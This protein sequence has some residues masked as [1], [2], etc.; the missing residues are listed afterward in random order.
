M[1]DADVFTY[2]LVHPARVRPWTVRELAEHIGWDRASLG[3]IR[4][5]KRNTLP[6]DIA[7]RIAEAVGVHPNVLFTPPL[8]TDSTTRTDR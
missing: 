6:A 8:S 7:L 4:S 1:I 3:H 2:C 5:G